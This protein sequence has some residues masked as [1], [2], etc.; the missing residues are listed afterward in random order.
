MIP[1]LGS[2]PGSLMGRLRQLL[3]VS[4]GSMNGCL[5]PEDGADFSATQPA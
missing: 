5:S 3:I 4:L 2:S 1:S